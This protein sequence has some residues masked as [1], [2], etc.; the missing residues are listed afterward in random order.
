M[1]RPIR[2][3]L[4]ASVFLCSAVA[5]A[6]SSA[7]ADTAG[8]WVKYAKNPILG[9]QYGTCFDISVLH[10][11]DGYPGMAWNS[12]DIF[13]MWVSWRPKKSIAL[14]ENLGTGTDFSQE[15]P[16]VVLA[17]A[18]TGWEDEVNRPVVI[19]HDGLYQMW[20]TGQTASHSAIGYATS[21]DGITWK[22]MSAQPVLAPTLPWEKVAVMCPDVMWDKD[23]K[24]YRMWYSGGEQ[25]E[26]NAIGYATSPD[27]LH[28]TKYAS[29]PVFAGDPK[30]PWE[31]QR[32]TACHVVKTGGW[33]YIFYIGFRDV[34][35]AQIGVAR[36]R[37]GISNWQRLPDNPIVR[38]GTG[39]WDND[40]CYKPYAILE[41]DRWML[42]YNGRS[43]HLEQIG[44]VTHAGADLGF[45]PAP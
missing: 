19:L 34:D 21:T 32:A 1:R 6:D 25:Y 35:H 37:D 16:C 31:Q 17:P 11:T 18:P 12:G 3:S 24:L 7:P 45:P 33:F 20:Y 43:E 42:W 44:V 23:A 38:S 40:A 2:G 28:W 41:N 29:N 14:V 4:L 39:K 9:G 22:R 36:S 15:G 13:R 26:P 5:H 10:V 27:G 30:I 8:G